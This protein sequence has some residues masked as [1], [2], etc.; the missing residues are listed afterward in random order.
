MDIRYLR[1]KSSFS[2][3]HLRMTASVF[4]VNF[5]QVQRENPET[6]S[7]TPE[8][9]KMKSVVKSLI[10]VAKFSILDIFVGPGYTSDY[11]F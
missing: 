10:F 4:T 2:V 5:E 11:L 1:V 9:S 3:E 7:G 8:I 6:Q